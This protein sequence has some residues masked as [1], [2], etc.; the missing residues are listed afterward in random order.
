MVT[1]KDF[2]HKLKRLNSLVLHHSKTLLSGY[3]L[4]WSHFWI[5]VIDSEAK[6]DPPYECQQHKQYGTKCRVVVW[7]TVI[8]TAQKKNN[9]NNFNN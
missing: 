7:T 2:T 5:S 3:D 9:N 8:L 6:W 1:L 4:K